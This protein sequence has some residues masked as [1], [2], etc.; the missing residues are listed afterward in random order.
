MV[1]LS[2]FADVGPWAGRRGYDSY[3]QGAVGLT[4]PKV[5]GEPPVRLACQPLDYLTGCLSAFAAIVMLTERAKAG[6]GARMAELSLARTAMWLWDMAEKIGPEA[7][8]PPCNPTW[9]EA[10]R[11]GFVRH[12]NAAGFGAVASLAPPFG[13]AEDP[14]NWRAPEPLGTST[15]TWL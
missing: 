9:D 3:V 2:A 15:P 11:E 13:F 7:S 14:L 1:T 6:G 4:A 8:P 10:E 12:L 5:P